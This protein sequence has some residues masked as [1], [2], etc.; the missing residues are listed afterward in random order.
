MKAMLLAA[1]RGE[2]LRPITDTLAKPLLPVGQHR[3]IEHHLRALAQAGIVDVVI[4]VSH[5]AQQVMQYLGD[6]TQYG[7]TIQYSFE[8][9]ALGSAGGVRQA[10]ALLGDQ[11]FILQSSDSWLSYDY[12]KLPTQLV[13]LAHL[14]LVDQAAGG[15]GDFSLLNDRCVS[16]AKPQ[17]VF[18]GLAVVAPQLFESV[19]LGQF[20]SLKSVLQQPTEEG[21]ID[22]E[23][24]SREYFNVN[25]PEAW[26]KLT[27][28][29]Q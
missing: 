20:A 8:P 23:Y 4:N 29:L 9:Q 21:L 15:G 22:G 2:R 27:E 19:E 12:K 1:G 25:T 10:L 17:Y 5:L 16:V 11:P 14:V 6:G 28:Y 3:L 26:Q 13:G 7:L 18:S 24:F